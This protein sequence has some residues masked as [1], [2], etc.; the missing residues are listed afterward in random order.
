M[1][2]FSMMDSYKD[3]FRMAKNAFILSQNEMRDKKVDNLK[4]IAYYIV[5]YFLINI[6]NYN[7]MTL[8]IMCC[9]TV[10][11]NKNKKLRNYVGL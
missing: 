4:E 9:M 11:R 3:R 1:A 10:C 7:T 8:Y 5:L 2:Y 6:L